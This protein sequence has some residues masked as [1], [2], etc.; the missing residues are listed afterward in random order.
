M[1]VLIAR[2]LKK[3]FGDIVAVDGLSLTV[4]AGEIFGLVGPDGAG[5]STSLRLLVGV[6]DA[7]SGTAEIDG[8]PIDRRPE[9]ARE[10][11]GYMPQQYSLYADLTVAENLRFF[12]DMHFVPK[13]E[14]RTRM[15]RL[16]EFSRLGPYADRR[17]GKLSGGMY[18]KLALSCNLMHT[19]KLLLLDEPTTGVDPLSRRELWE[20]LY[21]LA[22]E[23]VAI[24]VSTPYMDEAERCHRLG[25]ISRGR[26]LI[27]DRPKTIVDGFEEEVFELEV[28]DED[29]A[30]RALR[31]IA[32]VRRSYPVGGLLK[33]TLDPGLGAETI[34]GGLEAAGVRVLLLEKVRPN[35]EDIFLSR[36]E[37]E[38]A[39]TGNATL[40]RGDSGNAGLE[41]GA[42][43]GKS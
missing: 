27:V 10:L 4:S 2:D 43:G 18:K 28:E 14:R 37:S 9:E 1:P 32:G 7:D 19:P 17:A 33:V 36:M 41:P 16:Y 38:S 29:A 3:S 39:T 30:Q 22:E 24:V 13:A 23:G 34:A 6:L 26:F 8:I 12:A 25:L 15:Q 35:F 31:G 11:L 40:Q 5:K 42:P 21:A 20:I